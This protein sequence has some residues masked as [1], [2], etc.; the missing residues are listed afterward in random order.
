MRATNCRESAEDTLI[1]PTA[2]VDEGAKI[3]YGVNVWHYTHIRES[4]EIG[5]ET[6]I[7]Q[8]CYI[9]SR[10]GNRC[11]IQNNVNVYS[12][13]TIG[14]EVFVGPNATFTNDKFPRAIGDWTIRPIVVADGA[15]IGA[16]AV[17]LPGVTIGKG[18]MVGAGAVVSRD[19]PAYQIVAGVPATPAGCA[20][21]TLLRVTEDL[22][23][24]MQTRSMKMR[25]RR[26]DL[27]STAAKFIADLGENDAANL[28]NMAFSVAW[29]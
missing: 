16:G 19:V 20:S 29:Q 13:V 22:Q 5:D 12:G 28:Y 21:K 9:E 11:K 8:G 24:Y 7:G 14:D 25:S 23:S 6:S 1:H 4:A 15:S 26:L 17:I 2:T 3:G 18:A 27:M 10:I